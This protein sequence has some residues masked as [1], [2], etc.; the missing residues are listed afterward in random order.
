M[1]ED[2]KNRFREQIAAVH[3]DVLIVAAL[4]AAWT[5]GSTASSTRIPLATA[6]AWSCKSDMYR[7]ELMLRCHSLPDFRKGGGQ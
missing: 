4:D 7:D 6:L 3:K 1:T 2:E 5:A